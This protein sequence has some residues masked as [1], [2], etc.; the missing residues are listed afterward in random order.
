MGWPPASRPRGCHWRSVAPSEAAAL[1]ALSDLP[2]ARARL[3]EIVAAAGTA[4]GRAS[5]RLGWRVLPSHA[6][7]LLRAA[8]GRRGHGGALL[9]QGLAV[10]SY[11][12]VR[13]VDWLRIT[14]R[15]PAENDRLLEALGADG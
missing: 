10:R 13:C 14:V 2:A 7:F 15:A 5:A 1:G 12:A 8:A 4:G 11:P 9:R 3:A 6:N